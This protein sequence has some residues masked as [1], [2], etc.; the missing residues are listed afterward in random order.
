[1]E[2]IFVPVEQM[3]FRLVY[4]KESAAIIDECS[5]GLVV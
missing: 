5:F 3:M 2:L 1:M 4:F